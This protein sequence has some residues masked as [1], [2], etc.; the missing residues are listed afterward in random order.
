MGLVELL[1]DPYGSTFMR[2]ALLVAVLVGILCPVVGVWVVLRRLAYLGDA[3]SH[4]TLSGIAAAY[5]LGLSAVA[6]ALAAGIVMG[7][8]VAVIAARPR[9]GSDAAIGVVETVLFATGLVLI[10]AQGG[11]RVEL[12]HILLGQIITADIGDVTLNAALTALVLLAALLHGRDLVSATFDPL[13]AKGVGVP[14]APLRLV[15]LAM[16]S[17]AVVVSLQTV[18]LLMSVA[19]L[20]TPAATA[21]LCT[22]RIS[23][24]TAVA[25]GHGLLASV[26]GLTLSYHLASPPGATIALLAAAGFALTF[27]LT[28][29]PR[30]RRRAAPLE[31]GTA[32]L[33][34]GRARAPQTPRGACPDVRGRTCSRSV[35]GRLGH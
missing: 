16:V 3:M 18:G 9:L 23:T 4:G 26:G 21:R 34:G 30:R 12:D 5:L 11:I 14:E 25:V 15:V 17:I 19:I 31:T 10:S 35:Q 6:G 28:S 33:G 8:L 24:M 20:V 29:R 7:L 27:V 2:R 22:H 1:L 13:H 32:P